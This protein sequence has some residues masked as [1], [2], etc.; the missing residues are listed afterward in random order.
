[1]R[2]PWK[3]K[4]PPFVVCLLL[5]VYCHWS[6][7]G[8]LKLKSNILAIKKY[9]NF[10]NIKCAMRNSVVQEVGLLVTIYLYLLS[11]LITTPSLV[12]VHSEF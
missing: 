7:A 6:D 1:M 12:V 4:I 10:G 2:K 9:I 8:H 5:F 11:E 3:V